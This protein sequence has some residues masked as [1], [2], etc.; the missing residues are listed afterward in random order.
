LK[1]N[2]GKMSRRKAL[3]NMGAASLGLSASLLLGKALTEPQSVLAQVAQGT[4]LTATFD[5]LRQTS[6]TTPNAVFF[7]TNAGQEGFFH[8]DPRDSASVDNGG[9]VIV[10]KTGLRFKR[11]VENAI[12]N[13]KWF[14]AK[15]TGS[16]D[17]T[18]AIQKAIDTANA[19]GGGVVFIPE[20]RYLITSA[21]RFHSYT[22][23]SGAGV[24]STQIMNGGADYFFKPD[25]P[26]GITRNVTMQDFRMTGNENNAG[27][28]LAQNCYNCLFEGLEF[29]FVPKIA[30]RFYGTQSG[31][32]WN[33]VI[34]CHFVSNATSTHAI[35]LSENAKINSPNANKIHQCIIAGGIVG[36]EIVSAFTTVISETGFNDTAGLWLINGG[37]YNRFIANRYEN[38]AATGGGVLLNSSSANNTLIAETY[39]G[40]NPATRFT[41]QG[42]LNTKI[43]VADPNGLFT[44]LTSVTASSLEATSLSSTRF[45]FKPS[46]NANDS[47]EVLPHPTFGGAVMRIYSDSTKAQEN[48]SINKMGSIVSR[49]FMDMGSGQY[50]RFPNVSSPPSNPTA[51]TVY[52]DTRAN[53]LK[54][55]TGSRW[56]TI[57]SS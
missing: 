2:D 51:G 26:A 36:I 17:D 44:A 45:T 49:G 21:L 53:K 30:L 55:W 48:F 23:I 32:N 18:Q 5:D 8:Y 35:Q 38:S 29:T 7:V 43:S 47:F 3:V 27:G 15:G 13:V 37:R 41:D 28:I 16:I 11:M 31:C 22:V 19:K 46:N 6:D 1:H 4:L 56:E 9:T 20:G 34:Q 50:V 42:T 12:L 52:Y 33:N 25:N 10:S 54:L 39:A 40:G 57:T 24:V 14:G